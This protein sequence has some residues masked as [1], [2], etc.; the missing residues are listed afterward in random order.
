MK[1]LLVLLLISITVA[2]CKKTEFLPTGPTDV[3]VRNISDVTFNE[4][5]V[6][7]AAD[8]D[9]IKN[10]HTL[11]NIGPGAESGYARFGRA[12]PKAEITAVINGVNFSTGPVVTTFMQYMGQ[13][14]ITYEVYISN[15]NNKELKI[16]QVIPDSVLVLK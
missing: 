3:R 6:K 15:M 10:T 9:T 16:N 8:I 1:K 11:G 7:T 14:N 13:M 2:S 4:V 12:Y 5:T